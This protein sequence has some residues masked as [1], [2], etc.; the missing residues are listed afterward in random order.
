MGLMNWGMAT[1]YEAMMRQA[2]ANSLGAWRQEL[3]PS[4]SGRVLEVGVGTGVNL[5]YYP[6]DVT[7]LVLTEPD[8]HMLNQLRKKL[9]GSNLPI[10]VVNAPAE[11]LPFPDAAFDSAVV[12]LVLCSVMHPEKSLSELHRVLKPGGKL[13]LIEHVRAT[14]NRQLFGWQKRIEPFWKRFAGNCH[15]TRDTL[16]QVHAVGFDCQNLQ[17][18]S[19][20]G[21]LSIASPVIRGIACKS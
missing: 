11:V 21:A 9:A 18:D 17:T 19:M 13:I 2:E 7:E 12:T 4:A 1:F 3:L 15:L 6:E 5:R 8:R 16:Q 14:E 10:Q 20:R